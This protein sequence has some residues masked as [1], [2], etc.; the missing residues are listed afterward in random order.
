M[1][2]FAKT[3]FVMVSLVH[4]KRDGG[5]LP[6]PARFPPPAPPHHLDAKVGPFLL[7][8]PVWCCS[9]QAATSQPTPPPSFPSPP[10]KAVS[11]GVE[12]TAPSPLYQQ[13]E[14]SLCPLVQS[15]CFK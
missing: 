14:V 6:L 5:K 7:H 4:C 9:H 11:V 10:P 12:Q 3:R 15:T 8:L 2:Y 13:K 1:H